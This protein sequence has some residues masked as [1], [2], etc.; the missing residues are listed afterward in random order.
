[1]KNNPPPTPDTPPSP[2][3]REGEQERE[4]KKGVNHQQ[5]LIIPL[6]SGDR[7]IAKQ[8]AAEQA[9]PEKGLQVFLNVLSVLAVSR[10]LSWLQI[11]TDVN[12]SDCWNAGLRAIFDVADLI[13]PDGRKI[14]CRLLRSPDEKINIP[15]EVRRDRSGVIG[16]EFGDS[17]DEVKLLGF[18]PTSSELPAEIEWRDLQDLD[19]FLEHLENRDRV[20]SPVRLRDWLQGAFTEGW[21]AISD[22]VSPQTSTLAFRNDTIQRV[23]TLDFGM[24]IFLSLALRSA[25]ENKLT[26]GLQL[27]PNN[28][29][30]ELPAQLKLQVFTAEGAL[31]REIIASDGDRFI[32]YEFRGN[33]GEEFSINITLNNIEFTEKFAI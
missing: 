22:L 5:Q 2:L 18:F 25:A 19:V 24:P 14:E 29:S 17:F 6:L 13:L 7:E 30:L 32:Q 16:L 15:S 20:V 3:P 21:E 8:F 26:V 9:T 31:F 11:E 27:R 10:Y 28:F 23:K 12:S 33:L 1:M 4:R